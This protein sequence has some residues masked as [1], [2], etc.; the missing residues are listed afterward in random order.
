MNLKKYHWSYEKE[1]IDSAFI[2][3]WLRVTK[4]RVAALD[5]EEHGF[6]RNGDNSTAQRNKRIDG[7]QDLQG[8]WHCNAMT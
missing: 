4:K 6:R 8:S 7:A 1:Q 3:P 5:L 2:K